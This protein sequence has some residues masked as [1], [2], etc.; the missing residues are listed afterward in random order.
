MACLRPRNLSIIQS[1]F[2][3][4]SLQ[5]MHSGTSILLQSREDCLKHAENDASS[6]WA[7]A[8]S[9]LRIE[10]RNHV[11][12]FAKD[13]LIQNARF[14]A[15]RFGPASLV[16]I[17]IPCDLVRQFHVLHLELSHNLGASNGHGRV[18]NPLIATLK[19]KSRFLTAHQ[20][21]NRPFS[22]IR[23]KNRS[24]WDNQVN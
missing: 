1:T 15:Y 9:T 17:F 3:R 24:K 2:A 18:I 21:K 11:I 4:L 10:V 16:L 13:G 23:A 6:K 7:I 20:H 22:A 8:Q 19:R 14:P 12:N 5:L